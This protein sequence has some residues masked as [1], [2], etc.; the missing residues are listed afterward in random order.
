MQKA[1]HAGSQTKPKRRIMRAFKINEIS[2]VDVPAQEGAVAVIMKRKDLPASSGEGQPAPKTEELDVAK[3]SALTTAQEGHS[4]LIALIGH[5]GDELVSGETT[6]QDEHSHPWVKTEAGSIVIGMASSQDGAAHNHEIGEMSKLVED[7]KNSAAGQTGTVGSKEDTP[8]PDK[9]T[10]TAEEQIVELQ[11]QIVR[12]NSVAA[13]NDAEKAHFATLEGDEADTF[14][15]KSAD[16]RKTI[17]ADLTKAATEEDPVVYTTKDG[18]EL[19]KSVGPG[20]IAMA[21]SNDALRDHVDQ[22]QEDKVTATYEKRAEAELGHLPGDVAVRGA[23][24]KAIDG[25]EDESQ[26]EAALNALKAQDEALAVAFKAAGHDASPAPGSPEDKLDDLAK[27][28]NE[29]NPDL[30]IEQ[31][32]T[33]VLKTTEG[34][35]LYAKSV[36]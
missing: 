35:E 12:S 30:S 21:K 10:K 17:L 23:M 13:L 7:E 19:R 3:G 18:V 11:E 26:R 9:T 6:W 15:A 25:I 8:M 20:F 5:G 34:H 2:A 29:S 1:A 33:A 14:L 36:N 22:L 32:M 27:T 16:D 24:L 28:Y 31:S 4:H